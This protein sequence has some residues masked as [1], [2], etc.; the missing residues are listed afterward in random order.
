MG[1]AITFTKDFVEIPPYKEQ[2]VCISRLSFYLNC[3]FG[4]RQPAITQQKFP[5]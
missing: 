5:D 4:W 3:D 1:P 2:T